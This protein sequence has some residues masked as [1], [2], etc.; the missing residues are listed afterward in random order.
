VDR[1][2]AQCS[3]VKRKRGW[4]YLRRSNATWFSMRPNRLPYRPRMRPTGHT[5]DMRRG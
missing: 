1:L 3:R 5:Q 2:P 4:Q